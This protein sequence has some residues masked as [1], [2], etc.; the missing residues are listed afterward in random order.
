MPNVENL[1][2]QDIVVILLVQDT[3]QDTGPADS[4]G[5]NRVKVQLIRRK[6]ECSNTQN[7][8]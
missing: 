8:P 1:S 2:E 6:N 5:Q 3:K 7:I 4:A